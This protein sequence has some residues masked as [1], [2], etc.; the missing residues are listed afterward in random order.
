MT[1][2]RKRVGDVDDERV[3]FELSTIF[4]REVLC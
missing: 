3:K 2:Q 4:P 1:Y